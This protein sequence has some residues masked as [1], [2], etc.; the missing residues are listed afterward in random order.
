LERLRVLELEP[1]ELILYCTTKSSK[2]SP[3]LNLSYVHLHYPPPYVG[4]GATPGQARANALVKSLCPGRC[5]AK[6]KQ[7]QKV[8]M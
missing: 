3:V 1:L 8:P 7:R 2:I 4:G 6:I 5:P